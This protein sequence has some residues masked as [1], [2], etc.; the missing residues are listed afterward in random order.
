MVSW[1][2]KNCPLV[3]VTTTI[4]FLG[5]LTFF[6]S[7]TI[8]EDIQMRC[9]TG[10]DNQAIFYFD[11]GDHGKQ[12]ARSLLSS[13][14]IQLSQQSDKF[15]EALSAHYSTHGNGSRQPSE[16]VLMQCL[17]NML[18]LSGQGEIYIV[19]DALDECPNSSGYPTPRE[20]VLM[21][22]QELIG[23]NLP[24]VH[25]CIT[26]RPEV[27]IRGALEVFAVHN[28]SLHDQAGQNQDISDYVKSVVYSDS[29]PKMRQ[30]REEDKQL[31]IEALT[32]KAGGM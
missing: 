20:Q 8:V 3:C 31:V 28:V 27:D 16:D 22:L 32:E 26:S 12:D 19:V 14:L 13:I 9:Q 25:F 30:W 1:I 7:S 4:L 24:R 11:F 21:I 29:D 2:R 17:K 18:T 6:T 5:A 15:S 10:L 23:L